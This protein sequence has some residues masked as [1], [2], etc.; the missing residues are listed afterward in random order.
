MAGGTGLLHPRLSRRLFL[1]AAGSFVAWAQMPGIA[2]AAGRDPRFV[3]VILRGALDGLAAVPPIGDP[4]Y[5]ALRGDLAIGAPGQERA[6]PLDGFFGLNDAMPELH[7]MYGKGDALIV[8]A[9]A[10]A[11]R[12]RSHFDGQDVLENGAVGA[13]LLRTGWLNRAVAALPT[14]GRIAPATALAVSA[15]VPL[16]L[17]G[18]APVVTWTPPNFRPAGADTVTRLLDLYRHQDPELAAV[19]AAGVGLDALTAGHMAMG[20]GNTGGTAGA[21]AE[22]AEGAARLLADPE[23]PRIAALS[24]NGWDTHANEGADTGRLADLLAALDGALAA[25]ARTAA[26]VWDDT[27]IA[28]VTEFG[29]TAHGNGSDGTDHGTGTVAFVLGGAVAGGRVIADW[30]GLGDRD[31]LDARDLYPTTDLRAVLK[32]LLRDHLGLSEQVLTASVFPDSIGV[33]PLDGLLG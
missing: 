33:R 13:R 31:L 12:E 16:I 2:R 14:E 10:T 15:T 22:I 6:L 28:V 17:R 18:T 9:T 29:R 4:G 25:F 3:V 32:G 24:Y 21:F 20:G 5:A 1:G 26:P 8:H 23:G 27:V 11:Y 30:P 7:R 19:F